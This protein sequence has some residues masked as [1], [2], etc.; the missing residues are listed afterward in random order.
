[1]KKI[2]LLLLLNIIAFFLLSERAFA[3]NR[4]SVAAGGNW[5][6]TATWSTVCGGAG[7]ASIPVAGDVVT[8]CGGTVTINANAACASLTVNPGATLT[9]SSNFTLT[10]TGNVTIS[11]TFLMPTVG[12][13]PKVL[14]MGAGTTLT[15]AGT[16]DMTGSEGNITVGAGSFFN[17]NAG[18]NLI[19]QPN[20]NTVGGATLFTNTTETFAAT[21]TLTLLT[22]YDV[23]VALPSVI[24]GN[25]GNIVDSYNAVWDQKG[26][27]GGA[28][29]KLMG[30]LTITTGQWDFDDGTGA[31]TQLITGAITTSGTGGIIFAQ[32]ANRNLTLTTGAFTHNGTGLA[33]VMY[34]TFG[35]LNWTING[36]F[37]VSD[38][39][40]GIQG[41]TA[42]PLSAVTTTITTTGGGNFNVSGGLFDMNRGLLT[43]NVTLNISGSLNVTGAPGWFRLMDP[44][45][46]GNLSVTATGMTVSGGTQDY[47]F[48]VDGTTNTASYII[49][50]N[51]SISGASTNFY[52]MGGYFTVFPFAFDMDPRG[53]LTFTVTGTLSQSAGNFR[54]IQN[55]VTANAGLYT[56]NL[57]SIAFTGGT[58]LGNYGCRTVAGSHTFNVNSGNMS[59]SYSAAADLYA[60][61]RL[62]S[63]GATANACGLNF[64]I[65]NGN[66]SIIGAASGDFNSNNGSGAEVD[67][68]SGNVTI[69]NGDNFFNSVITAA[70][71]HTTTQTIGG[72]LSVSGGITH[73]SS[74]TGTLT[75][76]VAGAVNISGGTLIV[77]ESTGVATVNFNSSYTQT[78]GTFTLH[79]NAAANNN[80]VAVTVAGDFSLGAGATAGVINFDV[81]NSTVA[82]TLTLNGS[83]FTMG[84]TSR[85]TRATAGTGT[86]YGELYYNPT[87]GTVVY[88]KQTAA[89]STTQGIQQVKQFI[90]A[91]KI[92]NAT[93]STQPFQIASNATQANITTTA[94]T[95]NGTLNMGAKFI[96]AQGPSL[97]NYFSGFNVS[98]T[99][100]IQTSNVN[101]YYNGT[102][103]SATVEPQVFAGNANF[104]MDWNL[105][106]TSIVEYNGTGNQVVTG[107]FPNA[108][109]L[110]DC[111]TAS[112]AQ[113][114]YGILDINNLGT[115][116]TNYAYPANSSN[117]VFIRTQ[118]RLTTGEFRLAGSGVGQTIT[119]E[120]GANDAA[121]TPGIIRTAGYIKSEEVNAGNNRAKVQ[122]NIGANTGAHTFPFGLYSG[123]IQYLPVNF[124]TTGASGNITASTRSTLG[125]ANN[126]TGVPSQWCAATNV[127]AVLNMNDSVAA[128][129]GS[130]ISVIDRW[131]DFISS[132]GAVIPPVTVTFTYRGEENTLTGSPTG[133]LAVQHWNGTNWDQ[134]MPTGV[135]G[136]TVAG[137]HSVTKSGLTSFSPYILVSA[138]TPLPI[139][140]ISFT[141]NLNV[142]AV[143]LSWITAAEVNN[144]YF[145]VEK[146]I[147][148]LSFVE[149]LKV[150]GAGNSNGMIDYFDIDRNP[151]VG[152]S[153]YRLKQTDFDG[154]TSYSNIVPVEYNP[155]GD[156]SISLFPNPVN[157]G[158][159]TYLSLNQFEGKEVLV[160][161]RDIT[162]RE[163]FSK[164]VITGSNNE[165][166]AINE[167]GLLAKGSYLITA[168]SAN[169]IYNKKLIVK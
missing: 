97:T 48:M 75:T 14:V 57:G 157:V 13:A 67:I 111:S 63:L 168:T 103:A 78:G 71:G 132:V 104:R 118:L 140:L 83:N 100:K 5:N 29:Q 107:K 95:V 49:N 58:F 31:S 28:V 86:V 69:S 163:I 144:D 89:V 153:Y 114:K 60:L 109:V 68:I 148:G 77:K 2:K 147:D 127:G 8:I 158:S 53:N 108:G 3:A 94:L 159:T 50:G 46:E 36:N 61:N 85:M 45:T 90:N 62:A 143:A 23:T 161:L 162:G 164:V 66:L 91:A 12:N 30:T 64:T 138:L 105:N 51:A 165:L 74:E 106:A 34:E 17:M 81:A 80:L 43:G 44:D 126:T 56:M 113:Y 40:T 32:G 41:L 87:S 96:S 142:D 27:F 119:V 76:T 139:E 39:F 150:D 136:S 79:N 98:S 4:F 133:P 22:W 92:V 35:V 47:P 21:S 151:Y 102:N 65:S 72:T 169:N 10:T 33:A 167:E 112:T 110:T 25:F 149:V 141:A 156:P 11:G 115:V 19:W 120:N 130:T 6:T 1:M 154:K 15:L 134:S 88:N 121:A 93:G 152:I 55:V 54:G 84:G 20:T 129:D 131:W 38:D 42:G 82:N 9:Y 124:N 122:W 146:S 166:I 99:G 116:G 137:P 73:L 135:A 16:L 117:N 26:L 123:S 155:N 24:S 128:T 7:G 160:V 145:T 52:L 125:N 37:S 101:G 70:N 59:V 18:S